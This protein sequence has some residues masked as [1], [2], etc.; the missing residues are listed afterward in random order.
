MNY[1]DDYYTDPQPQEEQPNYI[2]EQPREPK[3]PKVR[4]E[5]KGLRRVGCF[6]LAVALVAGSCATTAALMNNYFQKEMRNLT[7]QMNDKILA[8]QKDAAQLPASGENATTGR[9]LASGGYLTPGQVYEQNVNAVVAITAEVETTDNYGRTVSG[10][11]SGTGFL[12]SADGYV[13]TN[14]HVIEGGKT[15]T[16]TTHDDTEYDAEIIGYEDNNDL[17]VLKIAGENM[18]YATIGKSA[19]LQVGDQVVAIGNALSTFTSSLTVGYVSGVDRVV[20][21]EGTAMNMIQSDVAINSGNSGGPLFNLKGEVVG[22]TTAKFSGQSSSGVGIEGISFAIP[23]D[24]VAGMI[25]DLQKFGYVTGAYLGVMVMDV[26]AS[27]QYYGI[28]AGAYV[29]SAT[30]GGAAQ[31]GGIQ[32]KDII[33][34]SVDNIENTVFQFSEKEI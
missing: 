20:D 30:E 32:A 33:T 29:E 21:T 12:I 23:M 25:E 34:D 18:P 15:V 19:D 5:R 26:E 3:P 28:P 27:A 31:K 10:L 2:Y 6:L 24:D 14:Y 22:I 11:S 17:A 4:K 13:I 9:P 8:A 16:V 7:Q 1:F